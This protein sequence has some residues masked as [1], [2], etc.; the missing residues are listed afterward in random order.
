MNEG[1]FLI[2]FDH[3]GTLMHTETRDF[4]LFPKMKE[5]ILDLTRQGFHLCVWTA[6][7]RASTVNSLKNAGIMEY[8]DDVFGSDDGLA[9]PHTMGLIKLTDGFLKK[10]ILHIGD[11][12]ADVHG[13]LDFGIQVIYACWNNSNQVQKREENNG[14]E[15]DIDNVFEARKI[16][17]C[18]AII[19]NKFGLS[20]Q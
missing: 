19:E 8:F 13:A 10:N 2:I 17:D 15:R 5:L 6:R 14:N 4:Y 20:L 3:D 7:G 11:S 1:P 9:K 18:R 12:L 16:D